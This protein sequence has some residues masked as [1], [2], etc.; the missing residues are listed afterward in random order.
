MNYERALQNK[1]SIRLF[2]IF[3]LVLTLIFLMGAFTGKAAMINTVVFIGSLLITVLIIHLI[4]VKQKDSN[5]IKYVMVVGFGIF[6]T[7]IVF[8]SPSIVMFASVMPAMMISA[9]YHDKLFSGIVAVLASVV[10]IAAV[11]YKLATGAEGMAQ[12]IGVMQ[13]A[14]VVMAGTYCY[15]STKFIKG[16]NDDKM[17]VV[18]REEERQRNNSEKLME[19]AQ[20]MSEDIEDSVGKM[21]ALKESI[22]DTQAGMSEI[23]NGIADTT[24]AVQEQ[25][26]MTSDIQ[27]QIQFVTETSNAISESVNYSA[28]I[29]DDS[30]QIMNTMLEDAKASETAGQ[31]VKSSL[32]L[33]QENTA[34]MKQ[35]VSMISDIAEQTSLLALNASIEAARAGEA[36]RGFAVVAGEV[37]NLSV[38]TQSATTDISKLIDEIGAQVGSVVDKTEVLLQNNAKQN[39]SADATNAKLIEV[40]NCSNDIDANSDRLSDAVKVLHNANTEIVNNVSNV[41]SVSEEVSAQANVSYEE[42]TK[43]L[44]IMDEVM[45]I[46]DRLNTSAEELNNMD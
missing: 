7:A 37:N 32:V 23:N 13:I 45:E 36:G 21:N 31:E 17:A 11:A 6:Y 42:S 12:D 16:I 38:Q 4:Y 3:C 41:S 25:L 46:I 30:M 29:I 44:V 33:L 15:M 39:E 40:K 1:V 8:M 34:S 22:A 28:Q 35:I 26:R 43:N 24:N 19:L 5:A 18:K 2:Q 10:N 27:N 9:M 14:F 20:S